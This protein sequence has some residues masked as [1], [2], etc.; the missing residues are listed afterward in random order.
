M[1]ATTIYNSGV[2]SS[3]ARRATIDRYTNTVEGRREW[4]ASL[5]RSRGR[6]GGAV[7]QLAIDMVRSGHGVECSM[8][9]GRYPDHELHHAINDARLVAAKYGIT[10]WIECDG[11]IWREDLEGVTH[12]LDSANWIV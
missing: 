4:V 1:G 3:V 8:V 12:P 2:R 6:D 10:L 5:S 11:G 7:H 9:L